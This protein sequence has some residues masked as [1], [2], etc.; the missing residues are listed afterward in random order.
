M[1]KAILNFSGRGTID[2]GRYGKDEKD[3]LRTMKELSQLI[4]GLTQNKMP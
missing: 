3:I 4:K 1:G 2:W